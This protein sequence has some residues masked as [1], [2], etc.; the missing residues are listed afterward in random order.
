MPALA[1][2]ST[3]REIGKRRIVRDVATGTAMRARSSVLHASTAQLCGVF[4]AL[5]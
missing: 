4:A 3:E 5:I 1:L 2:A